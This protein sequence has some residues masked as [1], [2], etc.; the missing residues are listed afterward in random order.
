MHE[1]HGRG[2]AFTVVAGKHDNRISAPSRTGS[3]PYEQPCGRSDCQHRE[4]EHSQRQEA[5]PYEVP[6]VL[7]HPQDYA[8]SRTPPRPKT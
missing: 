6:A 1:S 8:L 3:R 4:R 7:E 5:A 2:Q